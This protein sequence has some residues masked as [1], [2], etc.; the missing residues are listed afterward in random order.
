MAALIDLDEA[1]V[2]FADR[3][4]SL[5]Y[6]EWLRVLPGQETA[7]VETIVRTAWNRVEARIPNR[8]APRS[9]TAIVR[10][11]FDGELY[12]LPLTPITVTTVELFDDEAGAYIEQAALR[13][14]SYAFECRGE[15]DDHRG[16]HDSGAADLLRQ[17][18]RL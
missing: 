3:L 10:A 4:T 15:Y 8:F 2:A 12:R 16:F 9:F 7:T 6:E 14:A 17:Y 11:D 5:P 13:L 18:V 1:E